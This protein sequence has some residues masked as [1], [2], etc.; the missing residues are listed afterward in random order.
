MGLKGDQ[1]PIGPTGPQGHLPPRSM[2]VVLITIHSQTDSLPACLD[3]QTTLFQGFSLVQ[4]GGNGVSGNQDLGSLGSCLIRFSTSPVMSCT[5]RNVCEN[6]TVKVST[7]WLSSGIHPP[8]VGEDQSDDARA[9][10]VGRCVV[11]QTH[12]AVE[13]Q[14]IHSQSGIIPDCSPGWTSLWTGYSFVMHSINGGAGGTFISSPG[15]CLPVYREKPVVTCNSSL[16]CEE[17][18]GQSSLWL[19]ASDSG[20]SAISRCRVCQYNGN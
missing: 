2:T 8:A 20:G 12:V 7:S 19:Q 5:A 16:G 14:A 10:A 11:C 1:G 3:H 17:P 13:Q 15:S 18:D 6:S 9:R 4:L